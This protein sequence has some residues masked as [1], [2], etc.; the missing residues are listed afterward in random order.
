MTP[1]TRAKS[2]RA[3]TAAGSTDAYLTALPAEQRA[4]LERLRGQIRAAAP[5]AEEGIGYGLPAFR[6]DGK[7]L[8]CFG[9]AAG[10]CA[11]YPGTAWAELGVDLADYETSKGALRFQPGDPLPAALVRRIVKAR[12]SQLSGKSPRAPARA[13]SRTRRRRA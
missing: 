8:V 13:A 2:R 12:I 1:A 4:A 7:L 5:G 10:H 11:F 3:A 6:L 9:A